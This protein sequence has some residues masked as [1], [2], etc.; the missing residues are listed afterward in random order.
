VVL[1]NGATRSTTF[2]SSSQLSASISS[3][4]VANAG[5]AIVAVRNPSQQATSNT[6]FFA[7]TNPIQNFVTTQ[8]N[9]PLTLGSQSPAQMITADFNGDGMLDV[10]VLEE[11]NSTIDTLLVLLGNGDG[12][13]RPPAKYLLDGFSLSLTSGD[14]NEDGNL[15]L[16][17]TNELS[18]G[19]I[20]VLL[21][22]G[23]GTFQLKP[24]V[25]V[26]R[27]ALSIVAAD[28]N[29]D[30]HLDIAVVTDDITVLLGKG[31]GTFQSPIDN[32]EPAGPYGSVA[33]DFNRDGKMD[34]AVTN[35]QT[36]CN[37]IS[38]LLG[39]GDGT[40]TAP[41]NYSIPECSPTSIET[42]DL[43][44]DGSLDL[45]V[46]GVFL[47][48]LIGNGNGSFQTGV[49][50]GPEA[51]LWDTTLGDINADGHVDA[52]GSD[53]WD[54]KAAVY[55]GNGNGTFQ[56]Q[57]ILGS[58]FQPEQATYGDYNSDGVPDFAIGEGSSTS[59]LDLFLQ[60]T[61]SFVPGITFSPRKLAFGNVNIGQ[62][63]VRV[64]TVSNSGTSPLT[65]SF[66]SFQG[67]GHEQFTQTNSCHQPLYPGTSCNVTVTFTPTQVGTF[68]G[69]MISH[70]DTPA[71]LHRVGL[72]GVGVQ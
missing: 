50:F 14:F 35:I 68:I 4:D 69:G 33:G 43:N 37:V 32:P 19:T 55:F 23:D 13:M 28:F 38:V 25:P 70:D 49:A 3:A 40:L 11:S 45:V 60:G 48:S 31:D 57:V 22:N 39:N 59:N 65:I 9:Y 5:T 12:T 62:K 71:G 26:G 34:V 52:I 20:S 1:W 24:S 15:D 36:P 53:Q 61:F 58:F 16:I 67:N 27:I 66:F 30:G 47:N 54:H 8:V 64:A 10:A 51:L 63:A 6:E 2:V 56:D 46:G 72:R 21:G 41:A 7:I 18:G 29:R 44:G 17:A 42:A